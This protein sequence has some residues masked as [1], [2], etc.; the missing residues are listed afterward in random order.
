[1]RLLIDTHILLWWLADDNALPE[2]A[3]SAIGTGAN[4]VLVSSI[5]IAEIAIKSSLGKL[6]VPDGIAMASRSSGFDD[7][8]FTAAHA[9]ELEHLPWHH[10]DP[11]DR[12]LIAQARVERLTVVTADAKFGDYEVRTLGA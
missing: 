1:M 2:D 6:T 11:F 10:R 5:S 7:L 12:M 3:R 4:V 8:N 9:S